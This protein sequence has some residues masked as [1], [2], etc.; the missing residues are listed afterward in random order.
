MAYKDKN[1]EAD[2]KRAYY[3]LH[4]EKVRLY[5]KAYYKSH[6]EE[7]SEWGKR[8]HQEHKEERN[9]YTLEW[10][11]RNPDSSRQAQMR[12]YDITL[13]DY[14]NLLSIQGGVC[15]ICGKPE[16]STQKGKAVCLSV[17]HDHSTSVVRGLLCYRCNAGIGMLMED[18]EIIL[19]AYRY[20]TKSPSI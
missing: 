19:S 15:A 4:K 17:D 8:Y 18:P 10:R 6:K 14:D 9:K 7:I 16:T 5:N 11:E 20:V 3:L 12:K 13:E 1:K 2:N